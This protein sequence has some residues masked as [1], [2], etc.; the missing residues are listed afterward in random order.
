[1][2]IISCSFVVFI[3][4][5][6]KADPWKYCLSSCFNASAEEKL[7]H[8]WQ[9]E[10]WGFSQSVPLAVLLCWSS[11]PRWNWPRC[12]PSLPAPSG[13]WCTP[14]AW[15]PEKISLCRWALRGWY[16]GAPSG[17]WGTAG[18]WVWGS[19]CRTPGCQ[20]CSHSRLKWGRNQE[21]DHLM[22]V[23]SSPFQSPGS[24]FPRYHTFEVDPDDIAVTH[25][26]AAGQQLRHFGGVRADHLAHSVADDAVGAE[27]QASVRIHPEHILL[28]GSGRA[29]ADAIV[30]L[31]NI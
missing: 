11:G 30:I 17:G 19:A 26:V 4:H 14:P 20:Y 28:R 5:T 29:H 16:D 12:A 13:K 15:W 31:L 2:P 18:W 25:Q 7:L 23:Y 22:S 24:A 8:T 9:H 6:L 10:F 21:N 27:T 3:H 1:M